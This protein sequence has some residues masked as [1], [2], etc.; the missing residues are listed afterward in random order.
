MTDA[1]AARCAGAVHVITPEGTVVSAGR[2]SLYVL[3]RIGWHTLAAVCSTPPLVW[4]VELGYRLIARHRRFAS[5]FL[6]NERG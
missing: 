1:L 4:L 3:D 6:F 2:A 5:R